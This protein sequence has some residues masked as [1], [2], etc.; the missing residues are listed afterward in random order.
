MISG[1]WLVGDWGHRSGRELRG[2]MSGGLWVVESLKIY[3]L[4]TIPHVWLVG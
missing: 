1:G 3:D 4:C 2:S